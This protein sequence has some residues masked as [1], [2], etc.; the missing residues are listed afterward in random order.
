MDDAVYAIEG[1]RDPGYEDGEG[2]E[3]GAFGV[4]V[5]NFVHVLPFFPGQE[6]SR[7]R[8]LSGA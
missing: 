2:E 4:F 7:D 6:K 3:A 8:F 5:F 1:C